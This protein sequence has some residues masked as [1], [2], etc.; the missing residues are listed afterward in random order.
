MCARG[1]KSGYKGN[2]SAK[3]QA[4]ECYRNKE[5][6]FNFAKGERA[7]KARIYIFLME[8]GQFFFSL[9]LRI[10][11]YRH[12]GGCSYIYFVEYAACRD[13]INAPP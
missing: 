13:G 12:C 2:A 8:N 3:R 4:F 7:R 11:I 6:L 1:V 9:F 10:R 5:E